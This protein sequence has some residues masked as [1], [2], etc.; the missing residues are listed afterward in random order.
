MKR[1]IV[2]KDFIKWHPH[3]KDD[4]TNL[5][6]ARLANQ[7]IKIIE[8]HIAD[9]SPE[10]IVEIACTI[11]LY[12]ED[13]VGELGIWQSFITLHKQLY[14]RYLPFFEVN[15]ETYFIN[16][17]NIED[18]QF[19]VW[20]TLSADPTHIV[21][22]VNPYIYE[23]SKDLF[24]YC[25][26]R[27]ELLPIN[28]ALQNYLQQGDFMDDFTSMRFTLQ[29]LTLR[30]YLTN[31]LHTMEQFEA[32]QDQYVKTFY[33]DDA[34]LG[35]Y[36]AECTLAFS[37]KVGPLAL[38]PCEWLT[39]I[40]QLH[41]LEEKIQLLNEIKFRDIQCYKIIAEEAQGIHFLSYQKEELFVGYQELNLLPGALYGVGTVLMSLVYYQGK[42]EL[43]GIM[44]QMPNEELFNSFGELMQKTAPQKSK[45]LGIPH[46][47]ELM[48]L[49]GGSPLLYF[50]NAQAYYDF[51][52]N[53]LKLKL[54]DDHAKPFT[55][56]RGPLLA[57]APHEDGELMALPD[58]AKFICDAR[59]P[60]YNDK[61]QLTH[62]WT[63]FIFEAP[64][65][66]LRYLFEHNMLPNICFPYLEG[67]ATLAHQLVAENWD[68]LAR[69]L[70]GNDYEA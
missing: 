1:T 55:T 32:L 5:S 47:K 61:A 8:G 53:D 63:F 6:Y 22:P 23:L 14:G 10:K 66:L 58:A 67:D 40:L 70:K 48:K 52:K 20:K 34:K 30:C 2:G 36:M 37:Q 51:L 42:W 35:K 17:P 9:K 54:I 12:M 62:L 25:E 3:I 57:F 45:T 65:P 59:N 13:I 7:L 38:T 29:W 26:E 39:K 49:S 21:H 46:Y 33:S 15:E 69:F 50:K 27:F 44:S 56:L 43:N 24:D 18:I 41:G 4:S 68:F 60:Y 28:E 64:Q 11:A 16:E 31:S 19:L